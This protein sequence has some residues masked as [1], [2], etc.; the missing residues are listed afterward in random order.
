MGG[1]WG[2]LGTAR[3][4]GQQTVGGVEGEGGH[5][6][7]FSSSRTAAPGG[8]EVG[9]GTGAGRDERGSAAEAAGEGRIDRPG[10]ADERSGTARVTAPT[11]RA[12]ARSRRWSVR[13]QASAPMT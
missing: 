7:S 13:R 11:S 6:R 4:G 2:R 5:G 8:R 12:R 10:R 3:R 9:P 1:Q